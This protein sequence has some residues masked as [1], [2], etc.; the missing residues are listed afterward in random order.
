MPNP[1]V[2]IIIPVFN[3]GNSL[4]ICLSSI[5]NQTYNKFEV[6]L[7]NDGSSDNS[8]AI[9]KAYLNKDKRFRYFSQS[10][11]GPSVA[12]NVGIKEAKAKYITFIDADDWVH[13]DY[14]IKLLEPMLNHNTDLV[15]AGYYE[16]NLKF[17]KGLKLH[18]FE[19]EYFGKNVSKQLY[20]SNLFT[21]L[22]GVLW[23]KLFKK[24]I[25]HDHN[26][27]LHTELKLSED[28]LAVLEYSRHIDNAFIIPDSIYYYNRLDDSGLSGK[29]NVFKYR[30]IKILFDEID[31]Y[32]DELHFL[33]LDTIKNARKRS[34]IVQ[35]LRDNAY[36]KKHYYEIA[37]FLVENEKPN[38]IIFFQNNKLNDQILK[39]VFRGQYFSSWLL[40]KLYLLL[41]K[42]KNG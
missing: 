26:I 25:F 18:D 27:N 28:L 4:G 11:A 22:S 14:L 34:F 24:A 7:V 41:T 35:M 16:V 9:I 6:L 31:S 19:V 23:G 5:I 15:C 12:R 2:S 39:L 42:I 37:D 29:L 21:G 13:P 32:K 30:Y 38:D 1:K 17:P 10:N 3:A 8:E 20:Q 36:S 40:M 33:N